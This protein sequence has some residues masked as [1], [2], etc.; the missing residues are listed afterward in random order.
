MRNAAY[1]AFVAEDVVAALSLAE[2]LDGFRV[3]APMRSKL[4]SPRSGRL[5]PIFIPAPVAS[6]SRDIGQTNRAALEASNALII[7][8]SAS[9]ATSDWVDEQIKYF[10]SM[11]GQHPVICALIDSSNGN[12]F[13]GSPVFP[14]AVTAGGREPLAADLRANAEPKRVA[15]IRIAA[16][17]LGCDF[18]T[19]RQRWRGERFRKRAPISAIALSIFILIGWLGVLWIGTIQFAE[20]AG[21]EIKVSSEAR[22]SLCNSYYELGV[23]SVRLEAVATTQDQKLIAGQLRE[24]ATRIWFQCAHD[25]ER[26]GFVDDYENLY[27]PPKWAKVPPDLEQQVQCRN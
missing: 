1:I 8:C 24:S 4:P 14:S 9:S 2:A 26:W 23:A 19:L 12:P 17:M 7:C 5:R 27:C 11:H 16:A 15:L 25:E 18:D 13:M 6:S 3:P 21:K 22:V 20:V 10:M